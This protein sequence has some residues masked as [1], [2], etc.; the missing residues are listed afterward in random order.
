MKKLLLIT[1]LT[2]LN[3]CSSN[4]YFVNIDEDA[5]IYSTKDAKEV[6]AVIPK[7][8]GAY[9]HT[10][11]K[12]YRK[13]KWQNYKGWVI[14]PVYSNADFS[15]NNYNSSNRNYSEKTTITSSG[16]SIHVKG[17]TRKDGRYVQPHTRSAPR[18]R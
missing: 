4:Y 10:S 1:L 18:R 12:N 11:T 3:S 15:T 2:L 6:I 13:V 16:G 5:N 17:Y 9:I 14:N 7:G 8:Y